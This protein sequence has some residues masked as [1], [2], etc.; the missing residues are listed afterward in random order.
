MD[1]HSSLF[2]EGK[3]FIWLTEKYIKEANTGKFVIMKDLLKWQDL[4]LEKY[5]SFNKLNHY[6]YLGSPKGLAFYTLDICSTYKYKLTPSSALKY[7]SMD[8]LI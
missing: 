7:K 1:K 5:I 8:I 2:D 4:G 6:N 3:F